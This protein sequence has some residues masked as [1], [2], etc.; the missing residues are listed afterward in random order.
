MQIGERN[1]G[2][3]RLGKVTIEQVRVGHVEHLNISIV[4]I[5]QD[6]VGLLSGAV[7]GQAGQCN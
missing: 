5:D 2:I 6:D 3:R 7:I 4:E 1:S